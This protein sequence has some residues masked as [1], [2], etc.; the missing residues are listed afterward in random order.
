MTTEKT[1]KIQ[2]KAPPSAAP[3]PMKRPVSPA[4]KSQ[5][6]ALVVEFVR[7]MLMVREIPS[8]PAAG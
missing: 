6:R 4:S 7:V 8:E 3:I 1:T 2:R 5:V